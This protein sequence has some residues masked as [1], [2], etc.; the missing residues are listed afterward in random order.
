MNSHEDASM[1][2]VF[3]SI[4]VDLKAI[5]D[6]PKLHVLNNE[7]SCAVQNVHEIKNTERQ[8]VEAHHHNANV[9]ELSIKS[10]T[11]YII[12]HVATMNTRFQSNCGARRSLKCR[13]Y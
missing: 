7:C 3:T 12:S 9:A 1:I 6:K 11:Y 13:T 8:N 5:G 4:Y 10:V 2:K